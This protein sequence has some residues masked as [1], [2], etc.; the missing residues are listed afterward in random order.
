MVQIYGASRHMK[1][2]LLAQAALAL[3]V[4]AP[5][6]SAQQQVRLKSGG[7]LLGAATVEGADAK[8]VVG[9]ATLSVP[10]ADVAEIAA[11][12]KME[13]PL[14]RRLLAM[15]L[16]AKIL[17]GAG[18]QNVGL[19]A[20]ASR[21]APNDP[22]IAFWYATSLVDA[23]HGVAAQEVLQANLAAVRQAYPGA[24]NE[25][26]ARIEE[27]AAIDKL[28]RELVQ[29]LDELKIAARSQAAVNS[30]DNRLAY[31]AFRV[32]DQH[33][34]PVAIAR[35]A[36]QSS[37]NDERLEAFARGYYLY[38][39]K[40]YRGNE[41]RP[42]RLNIN[43]EGL[44]QQEIDLPLSPL[45]GNAPLEIVA[46]RFDDSEKRRAEIRIV[47]VDD[48][49]I[50]GASVSLTAISP[51]G[52]HAE[53]AQAFQGDRAG[54]ATI[55]AFPGVYEI[56]ADAEGF[57]AA[58]DRLEIVASGDANVRTVRLDRLI[59]AQVRIV[60]RWTPV[61]LGEAPL[62]GEVT[63]NLSST[64]GMFAQ[65]AF[66]FPV[67]FQQ[68]GD[69]LFVQMMA[70]PIYGRGFTA[71]T[72]PSLRW[73]PVDGGDEGEANSKET[74]RAFT[75]L[76]LEQL[77]K[78]KDELKQVAMSDRG[79]QG[80]AEVELGVIYVGKLATMH[81]QRGRPG[82]LTFKAI[83]EPSSNPSSRRPARG[84]DKPFEGF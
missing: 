14:P 47:D 68:S 35:N 70:Q 41:P 24:V 51:R 73:L 55:T 42:C 80:R 66:P 36:I 31:T 54:V 72:Q 2:A 37:G 6:A 1:L 62:A 57:V 27:R 3:F 61:E 38:S 4:F 21:L 8:V 64:T 23:G 45:S 10:L 20:E 43:Q 83:I 25:L 22:Q 69:K 52:A 13:E 75:S 34:Q 5:S 81:Q 9:D 74:E 18:K 29:R 78:I 63:T 16:E 15:A 11:V 46:H 12:A 76:N 32:V 67:R 49:P 82:E 56:R 28:P 33:G 7:V 17:S 26:L 40:Q 71:E 59:P 60:W 79:P 30:D 50:I 19:L 39:F 65:Q 84:G 44:K 58:T 77:D 48:K 53:S